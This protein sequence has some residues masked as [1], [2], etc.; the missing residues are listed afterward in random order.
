MV[1]PDLRKSNET[2][3]FF[4][5]WARIP[6]NNATCSSTLTYLPS[7]KPPTSLSIIHNFPKVLRSILKLT[8]QSWSVMAI[9]LFRC[10]IW[11]GILSIM[12][13]GRGSELRFLFLLMPL[14]R[15]AITTHISTRDECKI[16]STSIKIW[17]TIS[18]P[19][20]MAEWRM[21]IS[22]YVCNWEQT[23]QLLS[24]KFSENNIHEKF[25]FSRVML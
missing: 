11:S 2:T 23:K 4:L 12:L 19:G 8:M 1:W 7:F 18:H 10:L 5:W 17:G 22:V 15:R 24:C 3:L 14:L 9:I 16:S 21:I 13:Y 20:G 6:R 25:Q